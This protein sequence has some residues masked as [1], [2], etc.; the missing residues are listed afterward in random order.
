MQ[1]INRRPPDSMSVTERMDE[2]AGCPWPLGFQ[3]PAK[4]R[5]LLSAFISLFRLWH[6]HKSAMNFLTLVNH[7]KQNSHQTPRH[8]PA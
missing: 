3:L 8:K 6:F 7:G 4:P 1:E 2:V 5:G